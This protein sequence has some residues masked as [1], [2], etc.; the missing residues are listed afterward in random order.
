MIRTRFVVTIE[1]EANSEAESWRI[2]NEKLADGEGSLTTQEL[3]RDPWK[4]HDPHSTIVPVEH[5]TIAA[6]DGDTMPCSG[7]QPTQRKFF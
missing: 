5:Q 1:V 2:F 3:H 6:R 7:V 4:A